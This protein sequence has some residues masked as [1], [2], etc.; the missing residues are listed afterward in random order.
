MTDAMSAGRF[1]ADEPLSELGRRQV[2]DLGELRADRACCG[3]ELRTR[4]TAELAGLSASVRPELADLDAGDWRGRG[5]GEPAPAE[6]MAWLSEPGATPHGGE[7]ILGVI[8]R[9]RAWMDALEPG[10]TVAVTHPAVVRAAI[11]IALAAPPE[12]FWRI[13]VRPA[14]KTVLYR[15]AAGWTL[16]L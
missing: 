5:L 12:S 2:G 14:S 6:L 4:Q 8:D 10:R 13:D 1:P 3:P 16:R 11:L 7:S 15:R 9:V